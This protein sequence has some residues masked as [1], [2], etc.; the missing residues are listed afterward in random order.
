MEDSGRL[1]VRKRYAYVCTGALASPLLRKRYAYVP[2]LSLRWPMHARR[3]QRYGA[4]DLVLADEKEHAKRAGDGRREHTGRREHIR[5]LR[6]SRD[7]RAP[8]CRSVCVM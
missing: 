1:Y 7:P 3:T 4:E 8:P 5:A 6:S 2:V